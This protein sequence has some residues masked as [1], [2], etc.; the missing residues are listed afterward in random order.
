M[1]KKF[2]LIIIITVIQCVL[3][4]EVNFVKRSNSQCKF[5]NSLLGLSDTDNCC[6]YDTTYVGITLSFI[7]FI[8][9][10]YF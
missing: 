8:S 4:K 6:T 9:Y 10:L 3:S 5:V 7:H 2:I 1:K